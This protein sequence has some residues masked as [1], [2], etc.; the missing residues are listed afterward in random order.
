MFV[1]VLIILIKA[2]LVVF[3]LLNLAG[4]LTWAE[5]KQSAIMQDRVGP[6]RANIGKLTLAG[7]LHPVADGIKMITK[8]DFIP[9]GANRALHTLAPAAALFP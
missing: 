2:G 9:E 1:D 7:L 5:R 3:A 4:L 8:E 6:N